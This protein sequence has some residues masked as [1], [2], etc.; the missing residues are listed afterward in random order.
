[1]NVSII[2]FDDY[3][4]LCSRAVH[5]IYRNDRKGQFY[6]ASLD[7]DEFK[8]L[9][10]K[11]P[12]DGPVFASVVLYYKNKLFYRSGAA[13]RIAWRLRFPIPLIA[14]AFIFPPFF[15]NGIY[16][17]IARNRYKWFG[18]HER[19]FIP[20]KDLKKRYLT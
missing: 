17:W 9:Q 10:T 16:D 4:V 2:F 20:D 15:R 3:C 12:E 5:F 11:I 18:K 19:C 14:V 1:M 8:K 13:L 7:S 6:F